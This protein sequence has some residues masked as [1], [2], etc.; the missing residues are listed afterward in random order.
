HHRRD[1]APGQV[2]ERFRRRLVWHVRDVDLRVALEQLE[3]EMAAGA[4]ARRRV[5]Q[6]ARVGTGLGDEFLQAGDTGALLDDQHERQLAYLPDRD[7][8][9]LRIERQ[10]PG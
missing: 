9:L 8:V 3:A 7:Q 4:A 10:R 2:R 5:G 6:S 1:A